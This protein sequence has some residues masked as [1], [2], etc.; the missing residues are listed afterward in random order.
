[1]KTMSVSLPKETTV[2]GYTIKRAPLGAYL[3][4]IQTLNDFPKTLLKTLFGQDDL[5][6]IIV[7]LQKLTTA[8]LQQLLINALCTLPVPTIALLSQL[9]GIDQDDLMEDEA[10]GLDGLADITLA[11]LEVNGIENFIKT[12]TMIK[13]KL[14]IV[15]EAMK[16]GCNA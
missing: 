3:T 5:T 6:K 16:N 4:A 10:I 12:V 15:A 11:W 13:D 2:R 9:T 1:M 7:K 14:T 8:E